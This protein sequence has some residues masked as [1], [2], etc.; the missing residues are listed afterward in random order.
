[1]LDSYVEQLK[2]L[3]VPFFMSAIMS[4]AVLMILQL[5]MNDVITLIVQVLVGAVL[6]IGMSMSFK[7]DSFL[8]LQKF[9]IEKIRR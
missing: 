6:Y 9:L 3:S 1:M 5:H 4:L 8:Y 2:D 7:V